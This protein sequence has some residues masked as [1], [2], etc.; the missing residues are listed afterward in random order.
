MYTHI[1]SSQNERLSAGMPVFMSHGIQSSTS[2]ERQLPPMK[3][4]TSYKPISLYLEIKHEDNRSGS[5][6]TMFTAATKVL[7]W[8]VHRIPCLAANILE[9]CP[10]NNAGASKQKSHGRRQINLVC[11]VGLLGRQ[12]ALLRAES[13]RSGSTN[14]SGL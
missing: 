2:T 1:S 13:S 10:E 12:S 7:C 4:R 3:K 6:A 5:C 11:S 8:A 9:G 14:D